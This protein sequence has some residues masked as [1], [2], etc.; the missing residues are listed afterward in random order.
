MQ[1]TQYP[2]WDVG[3]YSFPAEYVPVSVRK[4]M[5]NCPVTIS[6]EYIQAQ[7]LLAALNIT[8]HVLA[9]GGTFVAKIF[10]SLTLRQIIWE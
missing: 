7:L 3:G 6:D 2:G 5:D 9:R 10:R 1:C 4:Y 8:T